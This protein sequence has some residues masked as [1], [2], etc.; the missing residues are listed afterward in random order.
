M[1]VTN[2]ILPAH[3]LRLYA[4]EL[5]DNN[6]EM[7]KVNNLVPIIPL[8][9]EPQLADSKLAYLVYGYVENPSTVSKE[10]KRGTL[11]FR[12]I[13]RSF[14]ELGEITNV[15]V[16][17]FENGDRSANNVNQ[18]SSTYAS[19]ALV[20]IRFTDLDV[21]YIEGGNAAVTE[22]GPTEGLV[23][24][25]YSYVTQQTVKTFRPAGTKI[26]N[27]NGTYTTTTL[28]EWV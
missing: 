14:A 19:A 16:R 12:I 8:G 6:T 22:G 9:E 18:W 2:K 26:R 25:S 11:S 10:I 7:V 23:N 17:A 28:N 1:T 27:P 13:A 15:L 4:W 21:T 20:G 24:V 3:I 5:L